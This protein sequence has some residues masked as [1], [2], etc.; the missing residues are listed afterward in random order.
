MSVQTLSAREPASLT[1]LC[2]F[3]FYSWRREEKKHFS[4]AFPN[5]SFPCHATEIFG[6]LVLL[7]YTS[8]HFVVWGMCNYYTMN[9][10]RFLG[11]C[12]CIPGVS[13]H[14]AVF[15]WMWLEASIQFLP[16]VPFVSVFCIFPLLLLFPTDDHVIAVEAAVSPSQDRA[17]FVLLTSGL[18]MFIKFF[19]VVPCW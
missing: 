3:L 8:W 13:P 11:E 6:K 17:T 10:G 7:F 9:W 18:Y 16:G 4:I 14:R 2:H 5:T 12:T 15:Q 1:S 19:W